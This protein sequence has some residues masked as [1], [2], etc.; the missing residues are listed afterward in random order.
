MYSTPFSGDGGT[1]VDQQVGQVRA[2]FDAG[3]LLV[4]LG[5]QSA[6]TKTPELAVE[7]ETA[8]LVPLIQAGA[9]WSA[10]VVLLHAH[11]ASLTDLALIP[12][13]ALLALAAVA[14][15]LPGDSGPAAAAA[16]GSTGPVT[17]A[18]SSTTASSSGRS[19]S[20]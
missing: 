12:A 15:L 4:D 17:P 5:G 14:S 19:W 20:S 8:R 11:S 6:N 3:A 16:T 7:E 2:Q 18:P 10:G 1:T 13:F 9:F